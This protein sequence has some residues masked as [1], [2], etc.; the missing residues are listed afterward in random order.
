[1]SASYQTQQT[2]VIHRDTQYMYNATHYM[3][4]TFDRSTNATEN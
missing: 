1:M 4:L 2:F 3:L